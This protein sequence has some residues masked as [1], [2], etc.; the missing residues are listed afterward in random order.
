MRVIKDGRNTITFDAGRISIVGEW[1]SNHGIAYEQGR[2]RIGMDSAYGL[3]ARVRQWLHRQTD[4][5]RMN[6]ERGLIRE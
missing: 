5:R 2:Q 1:F 6:F 3:T 4:Q